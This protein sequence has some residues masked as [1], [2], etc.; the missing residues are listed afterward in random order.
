M[1]YFS[2]IHLCC[3]VQLTYDLFTPKYGH[4]TM[5]P[6]SRHVHTLKFIDLFVFE[7]FGHKM[8]ILWPRS[9]ATG[10]AIATNLCPTSWGVVLMLASKYE[11][12]LSSSNV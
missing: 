7:I 2:C 1:A 10:V 8:Q 3:R 4:V 5:T 6:C 12:V 9:W 11:L